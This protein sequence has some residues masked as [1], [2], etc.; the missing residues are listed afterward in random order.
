MEEFLRSYDF[1]KLGQAVN[2][3]NFQVAGMTANRMLNKAKELNDDFFVK[4]LTSI[5][6]C[7][8]SRNKEQSLNI[9]SLMIN[10]RARLLNDM[11]KPRSCVLDKHYSKYF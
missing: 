2:H 9:L 6:Q 10:K 7:I 5:R 11:Y 8:A 4:K 3:C 1:M